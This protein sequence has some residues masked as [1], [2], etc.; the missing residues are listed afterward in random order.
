MALAA[1]VVAVALVSASAPAETVPAATTS[2]APASAPSLER[3]RFSP[4]LEVGYGYQ[5]TAD[6]AVNGLDVLGILAGETSNPHESFRIGGA[7]GVSFGR[8][9]GGV[10]MTTT[11]VGPL[12]EWHFERLRLGGGPRIGTF[13]FASN[14]YT[15]LDLSVGLYARVSV[16]L[17][18]FDA[19]RHGALYVAVKGGVDFTGV[20]LYGVSLSLGARF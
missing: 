5:S 7:I 17:V 2:E 19:N 20:G 8:T 11:T 14:G 16:D 10:P 6:L 15:E 12:F 9:E 1:W 3:R 18:G 4:S 13:T